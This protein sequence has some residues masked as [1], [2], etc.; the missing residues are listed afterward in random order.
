MHLCV[1]YLQCRHKV[2]QRLPHLLHLINYIICRPPSGK[3]WG[4]KIK[5]LKITHNMPSSYFFNEQ[6]KWRCDVTIMYRAD[7]VYISNLH[8][9]NRVISKPRANVCVYLY[10][11]A[12]IHMN[13]QT[14]S[15]TVLVR[16]NKNSFIKIEQWNTQTDHPAVTSHSFR[17]V[18][19][20]LRYLKALYR[21]SF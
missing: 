19:V 20:L 6:E 9:I 17:A 12:F 1:H 8:S 4:G 15:Y 14:V 7:N 5:Y 2:W 3:R 16:A 21:F 10:L 13:T 18:Y 11:S